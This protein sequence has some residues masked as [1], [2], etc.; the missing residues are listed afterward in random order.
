M[1][2]LEGE[3]FALSSMTATT[4]KRTDRIDRPP[5]RSASQRTARRRSRLCLAAVTAS[6]GEPKAVEERVF[7]SQ[8]TAS[9]RAPSMATRSI[10]PSAQRQLRAAMS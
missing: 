2:D 1:H 4:S 10:S 5:A 6:A 9:D 7:T 3:T 8:I